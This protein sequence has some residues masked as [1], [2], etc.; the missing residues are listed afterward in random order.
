MLLGRRDH[1]PR[2]P[3]NPRLNNILLLLLLLFYRVQVEK[4]EHWHTRVADRVPYTS[5]A[6]IRAKAIASTSIKPVST[7]VKESKDGT[8]RAVFHFKEAPPRFMIFRR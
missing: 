7:A 2:D 6:D 8:L 3:K 5:I 1:L 4:A